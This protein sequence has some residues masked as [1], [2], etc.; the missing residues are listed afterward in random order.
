[1]AEGN[2]DIKVSHAL[3]DQNLLFGVCD[4][5]RCSALAGDGGND[6]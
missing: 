2:M 1:M 5:L 6:R 3:S 4:R